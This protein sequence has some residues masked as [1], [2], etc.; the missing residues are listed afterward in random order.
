[1]KV[2]VISKAKKNSTPKTPNKTKTK[3]NTVTPNFSERQCTLN[4]KHKREV[5]YEKRQRK[6]RKYD[7]QKLDYYVIN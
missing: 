3:V 7:R 2:G 6:K 1:M 5:L 4:R